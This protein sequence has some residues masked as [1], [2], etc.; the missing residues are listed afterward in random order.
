MALGTILKRNKAVE[1]SISE[2]A[3]ETG[4]TLL[5]PLDVELTNRNRA[6]LG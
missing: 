3:K 4:K 2:Y 5:L 6:A 1:K